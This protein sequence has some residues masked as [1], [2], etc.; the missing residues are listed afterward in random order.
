M[1]PSRSTKMPWGK[2]NMPAPKLLTSLPVGSKWRIGSSVEFAQLLAPQ[3]SATQTLWPSLSMSTALVAPQTRPSGSLAQPSIVRNGLGGSAGSCACGT[4]SAAVRHSAART[5][6]DMAPKLYSACEA[7]GRRRA[8]RGGALDRRPG[9]GLRL[10]RLRLPRTLPDLSEHAVRRSI[11]L[12]P[13][14][15]H[16]P[17]RRQLVRRVAG[18]VA[19]LSDR[20]AE[21]DAHHERGQR[22]R[23][24]H[25]R[26]Q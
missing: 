12:R 5:C 23:R 8:G 1:L 24:A 10:P 18:V 2:V 13:G 6:N 9:A 14:A 7:F 20:R 25:R 3:R 19:R 22:P 16:A 11:H 21:P 15:L 26:D 17:A 4:S